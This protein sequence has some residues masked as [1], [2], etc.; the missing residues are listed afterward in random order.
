[1]VS[2]FTIRGS[3]YTA[4]VSISLF[5]YG[6]CSSPTAHCLN[7]PS[8]GRF[9]SIAHQEADVFAIYTGYPQVGFLILVQRGRALNRIHLPS[10]RD[11]EVRRKLIFEMS[12]LS[13]FLGGEI[14][15]KDVG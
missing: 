3:R 13:L 4:S 12:D 11:T 6:H 9:E 7:S 14:A 10:G 8:P 2:L 15:A 1:M 5:T